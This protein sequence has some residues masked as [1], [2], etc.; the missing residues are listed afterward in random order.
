MQT[1]DAL[2][3]PA[4]RGLAYREFW[5]TDRRSRSWWKGATVWVGE[6]RARPSR[7]WWPFRDLVPVRA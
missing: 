7:R 4:A 6:P 1:L 5:S 2:A 3:H